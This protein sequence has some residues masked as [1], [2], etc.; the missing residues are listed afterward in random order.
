MIPGAGGHLDKGLFGI[1]V[2]ASQK[3]E[4]FEKAFLQKY[5]D[6]IETTHHLRDA[7]KVLLSGWTENIPKTDGSGILLF[8]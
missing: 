2:K 4:L 6:L 3:K 1:K 5:F 7:D 8:I